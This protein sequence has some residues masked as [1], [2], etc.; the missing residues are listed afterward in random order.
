M[1]LVSVTSR[2]PLFRVEPLFANLCFCAGPVMEGYLSAL[3]HDRVGI[4]IGLFL[5]GLIVA[6]V[7][8]ILALADPGFWKP[9]FPD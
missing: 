2:E 5:L 8:T 7:L 3:G 4:R 9:L 6:V 1:P